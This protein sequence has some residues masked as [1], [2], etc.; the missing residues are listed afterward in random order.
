VGMLQLRR[1]YAALKRELLPPV[2]KL[3]RTELEE[4]LTQL[5]RMKEQLAKPTAVVT[6]AT[7]GVLTFG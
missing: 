7:G 1:E 2:A 4:R 6:T 5:R 3:T